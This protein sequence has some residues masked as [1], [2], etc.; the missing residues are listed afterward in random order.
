M[1]FEKIMERPSSRSRSD[2]VSLARP[3]K[4]GDKRTPGFSRA[5]TVEPNAFNRRSATGN[6]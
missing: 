1:V 5:A 3:F 4:A 2:L 6:V